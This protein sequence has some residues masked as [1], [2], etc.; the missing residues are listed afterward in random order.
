MDK[1]DLIAALRKFKKKIGK[2][3]GVQKMILFGSRATDS[4]KKDS[5]VDVIIVG[6]FKEKGNAQRTPPLY[7][8]WSLDL[9]VDFICYTPEEYKK[10]VKMITIA[11]EAKRQGIEI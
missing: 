3:Y 4:Y 8:D 11:R 6:K 7:N 1:K 10:L 2:K 5:D 9:P